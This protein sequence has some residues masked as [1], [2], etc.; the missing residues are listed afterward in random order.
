MR[1]RKYLG[2]MV[3]GACPVCHGVVAAMWLDEG[4]PGKEIKESIGDWYLR[5]L[6]IGTMDRYD[7]DPMPPFCDEPQAHRGA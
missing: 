2:K 5:G 6:E 1:E 4:I 7:D 3:A